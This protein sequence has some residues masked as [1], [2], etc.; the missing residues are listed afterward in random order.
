MLDDPSSTTEYDTDI[1][2]NGAPAPIGAIR[3]FNHPDYGLQAY[4]LV[5]ATSNL[6]AGLGYVF[7]AATAEIVALPGGANPPT[8]TVAGIPQNDI[9][10]G[11]WGWALCGGQGAA[12]AGGPGGVT[13]GG[14]VVLAATAKAVDV[15]GPITAPEAAAVI[16]KANATAALNVSFTIFMSG[17]L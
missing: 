11:Y 6:I 15:T 13:A 2:A 1:A 10:S 5:R 8:A 9:D 12:T 16:G 4:R 3:Y 14:A 17:L 7:S